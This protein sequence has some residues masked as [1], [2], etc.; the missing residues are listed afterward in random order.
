VR[1]VLKFITTLAGAESAAVGA[2]GAGGA[3]GAVQC[4][5]AQC[6]APNAAGARFCR[7]CGTPVRGAAAQAAR[8]A[9]RQAAVW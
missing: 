4:G 1:L 7:R 8:P 2:G 6:L 9:V 3:A 5:N